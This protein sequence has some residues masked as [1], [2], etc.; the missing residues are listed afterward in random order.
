MELNRAQL[1]VHANA[2]LNKF[3]INLD[4]P[5][6]VHIECFAPNEDANLVEGNGD[7]IPVHTWMIHQV[8]LRF[9]ISPMMKTVMA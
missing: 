5:E 1:L 4:I 9:P 3:R 2:T 8:G 7:R 6:D